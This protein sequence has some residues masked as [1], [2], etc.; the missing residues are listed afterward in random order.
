MSSSRIPR[1]PGERIKTDRRDA[2]KLA[3]LYS[4][5]VLAVVRVPE[6]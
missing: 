4:T 3:T 2:R 1:A 6:R 5:G